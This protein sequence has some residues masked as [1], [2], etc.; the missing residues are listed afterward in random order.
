MANQ[1]LDQFDLTT[2]KEEVT[3]PKNTGNSLL[4]QF[5]SGVEVT[6]LLLLKNQKKKQDT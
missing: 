5:N 3:V 2:K 6:T 1:L 4:D